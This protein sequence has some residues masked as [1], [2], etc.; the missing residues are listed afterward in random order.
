VSKVDVPL[1]N[2]QKENVVLNFQLNYVNGKAAFNFEKLDLNPNTEALRS[3]IKSEAEKITIDKNAGLSATVAGKVKEVI[4]QHIPISS[5]Y[6]DFEEQ[7]PV[8]KIKG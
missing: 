3:L 2:A 7:S 4:S 8:V 6:Y 5:L 1:L